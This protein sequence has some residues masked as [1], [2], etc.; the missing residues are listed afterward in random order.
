MLDAFFLLSAEQ[1]ERL[2]FIQHLQMNLD[3]KAKAFVQTVKGNFCFE[4]HSLILCFRTERTGQQLQR[5]LCLFQVE[6]EFNKKVVE[7]EC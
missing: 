7:F 5:E 2:A 6:F 1:S 3:Y 4:L